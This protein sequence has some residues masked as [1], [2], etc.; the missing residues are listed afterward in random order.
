MAL[1]VCSIMVD[2][3]R[4]MTSNNN[5]YSG[6]DVISP[7]I[8]RMPQLAACVACCSAVKSH[9]DRDIKSQLRKLHQL[10]NMCNYITGS[11][12]VAKITAPAW[13]ATSD[14]FTASYQVTSAVHR[15]LASLIHS[16]LYLPEPNNLYFHFQ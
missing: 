8:P 16:C 7:R 5:I 3:G 14:L 12:A 2:G 6:S 4:I 1:Y 15:R 10:I 9:S 11:F 13:G